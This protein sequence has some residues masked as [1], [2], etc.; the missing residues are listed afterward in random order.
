MALIDKKITDTE[1]SQV[2]VKSTEGN[3]LVGTVE[4]NKNVFDKYPELIRTK[5][6]ELIDLL[7]EL[8]L[9]NAVISNDIG[10]IRLNSDRVIETS[11]DG[12]TWEATGS[13][14]HI[15]VDENG[16]QMTQ[17]SRLK[18]NG[19][20]ITDDGINTVIQGIK[21]DTGDKGD[22][23]EKGDKGDTGATGAQGATGKVLVPEVKNGIISWTLQDEPIVPT[24]QN[25]QGPQ[26]VQGVQGAQGVQGERGPQGIQGP[27]GAQGIQGEQ[28]PAG[29]KGEKGIEY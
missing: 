21:G 8:G 26:G 20:I 10:Q 5:L 9:D 12:V 1:R 15:I 25:I 28:G 27:A 4:E 2:Y 17:R 23:G 13:S 18:F 22:K 24:A 14:G 29:A 7:S 19:V 11:A 3:R 16:N 6:N